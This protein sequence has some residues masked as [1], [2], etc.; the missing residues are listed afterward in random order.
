MVNI[1]PTDFA[2]KLKEIKDDVINELNKKESLQDIGDKASNLVFK[3]TRLGYG[4]DSQGGA[5][6]RLNPLSDSY[7]K[8]RKGEHLSES[9]TPGKS[10]LTETGEM[11]NDLHA[12][13]KGEGLINIGFKTKLSSDKASWNTDKGRPFMNLSAPE[14]KQLQN[15]LKDKLSQIIDKLIK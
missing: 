12:I 13:V 2:K 4:V 14:I 8:V 9:T 6:T 10:N 15:Y 3:R 11:L 5:K 7:K 1:K